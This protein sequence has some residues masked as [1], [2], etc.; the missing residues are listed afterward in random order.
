MYLSDTAGYIPVTSLRGRPGSSAP[1]I[2]PSGPYHN[3]APAADLEPWRADLWDRD[4]SAHR[5]RFNSTRVQ[6][7]IFNPV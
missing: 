7:K 2:P 6:R 3:S 5:F 1:I 4:Y